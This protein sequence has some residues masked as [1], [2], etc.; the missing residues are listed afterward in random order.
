MDHPFETENWPF[1]KAKHFRQVDT[2]RAVRVIVIHDM[3][4]PETTDAA[5]VIAKDFATTNT[6]KSAHI[7]VDS[8]S[9]V[10]CV[11]DNNVAFAAPGANSDGIQIELTGF[12]KQTRKQ[13]LDP[14]GVLLLDRGADATAQYCL[15]YDIP[16]RQLSNAQLGDRVSKGI[17]GHRQVSAVFKKSTHTDPGPN[18]PWDFFL[19]RVQH[20]VERRARQAGKV[21]VPFIAE[22]GAV[23]VPV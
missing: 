2:R 16:A 19:E 13:W 12:A 20:H 5:E 6:V 8:N 22:P 14:Y 23:P 17:V 18:F 7:C 1:V 21:A 15:K 3:E 4:F 11:L 10:Q 9:I